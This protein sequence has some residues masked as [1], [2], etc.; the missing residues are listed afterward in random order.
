[1]LVWELTTQVGDS[2]ALRGIE[3]EFEPL[4][5]E[6]IVVDLETPFHLTLFVS[7]LAG[8]S[9]SSHFGLRG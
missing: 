8:M 1:M 2:T 5:T 6:T 4:M 9:V 7:E 3:V